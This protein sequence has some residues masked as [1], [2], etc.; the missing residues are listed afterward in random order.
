MGKT[1]R[2]RKCDHR[3]FCVGRIDDLNTESD[4]T[5]CCGS[6]AVKI[7]CFDQKMTAVGTIEVRPLGSK[8]CDFAP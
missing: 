1:K 6:P 8:M 3:T 2:G 4:F 5:A 7:D